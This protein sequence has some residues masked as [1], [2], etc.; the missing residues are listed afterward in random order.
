MG[1]KRKH[2]GEKPFRCLLK[3]CL[4]RFRYKGDLSKHIKKYHPGHS[5]DLTPVPLQDD[6]LLNLQQQ[7]QTQTMTGTNA[8]TTTANAQAIV[9]SN[10]T[11][12][13]ADQADNKL[14]MP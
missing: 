14:F 6:E 13:N 5:Q 9:I 1:H 3:T 8:K 4:K 11:T 7:N 2:T 12:N 10:A